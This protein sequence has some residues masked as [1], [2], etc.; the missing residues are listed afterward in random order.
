MRGK[1]VALMPGT[2]ELWHD[3]WKSYVA[4]PMMSD[5][6]HFYD[7]D[8]C[9]K[10]YHNKMNDATR[11]YFSIIH[12]GKVIGHIYLKHIDWNKK[13]S[14]YG[15]ALINDSVKG[16][17]YGTEA[18][19]LLL[20]YAFNVLGFEVITANSALRNVRSQHVLAKIGF[21]HTHSDCNFK[22]YSFS[23]HSWTLTPPQTPPQPRDTMP[24]QSSA[25]T[26]NS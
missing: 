22:Y 25:D 12:D 16:K 23:R 13:S 6:Q 3:F 20:D 4:D 19:A 26:V 24:L 8:I 15:I 10:L 7:Y 21:V 1:N 11:K 17:G 5:K 14:E 9:E 2:N 18:I